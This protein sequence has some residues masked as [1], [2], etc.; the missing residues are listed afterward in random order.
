MR[1]ERPTRERVVFPHHANSRPLTGMRSS[2]S[3]KVLRGALQIDP[4]VRLIVVE[5]HNQV[6]EVNRKVCNEKGQE[7]MKRE[8]V[9][10]FEHDRNAGGESDV[11]NQFGAHET[12]HALGGSAPCQR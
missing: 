3:R 11:G 9:H 10:S 7:K 8:C 4:V 1:E 5:H 12:G 6:L 2:R